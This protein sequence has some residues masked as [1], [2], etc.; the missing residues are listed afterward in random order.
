MVPQRRV[1]RRQVV[2]AR[3]QAFGAE[4]QDTVNAHG[5]LAYW[6]GSAGDP[7]PAR[8]AA[9][10]PRAG[11][12]RGA[13][14]HADRR[15]NLAYWTGEAGDPAGARDQFTALLPVMERVSGAEHPGRRDRQ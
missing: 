15:S 11:A 4:H 8:G 2:A 6:T 3:E 10:R 7:G 9:A 1:P 14:L 5:M 13:P 12:Q